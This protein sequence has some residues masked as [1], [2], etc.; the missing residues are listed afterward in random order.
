M[1]PK[2]PPVWPDKNCQMSVKVAENDFSV[3]MIDFNT[4]TK[5]A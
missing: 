4:F 1:I 5:I 3:K 2:V